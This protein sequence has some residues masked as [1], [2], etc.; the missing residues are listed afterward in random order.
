[1]RFTTAHQIDLAAYFRR[2]DYRGNPLPTLETLS[3]LQAC[4][5][6]SIPFENLD[7]F[8]NRPVELSLD[9]LEDKL[10]R[11]KRG[12]YCYEHNLI[13][14]HVLERLGLSVTGLAARVVWNHP[15]DEI[16]PRSHML[17][18]VRLLG[19]DTIVDVGFGAT[20]PTA[21]LLLATSEPQDTVQGPYRLRPIGNEYLLQLSAEEHWSTLYRFDLSE[22]L[23]IDYEG[24]NYYLSTHDSSH[25]RHALYGALASE[26]G[27]ITLHNK[28]L[29][30]RHGR[31][32]VAREQIN[33]AEQAV[34][35]L[36]DVF[37]IAVPDRDAFQSAWRKLA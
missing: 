31:R 29:T 12:G 30:T 11:N 36:E 7:P 3:A 17:L 22:Q 25:F 23:P 15:P 10:I 21:P 19:L 34:E 8:L 4:H 20:T 27:R 16:T 28:V 1:M 33:S 18:R 37:G 13:F 5:T 26:E 6:R 9:A 2:I 35:R 32:V 14:A 24:V